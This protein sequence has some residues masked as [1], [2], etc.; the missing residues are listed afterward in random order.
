MMSAQDIKGKK[1]GKVVFG[2]YEASE[3]DNYIDEIA[4]EITLLQKEIL[5]L[6]EQIEEVCE[7]NEEYKSVE[8]SMRKALIS[9]QSIASDMIDKANEERDRILREASEIA[10][11]QIDTYRKQIAQEQQTLSQSQEKTAKF[12][13]AITAFYEKQIKEV[14]EFS[15]EVPAISD[16][17]MHQAKIEDFT[18]DLPKTTLAEVMAPN[19][20]EKNGHTNDILEKIRRETINPQTLSNSQ[21]IEKSEKEDKDFE[22]FIDLDKENSESVVGMIDDLEVKK[23]T[24]KSKFDISELEFGKN[25]TDSNKF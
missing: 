3:V 25:H 18:L 21:K 2:G 16:K 11:E 22:K 5:S 15:R 9:A 19:Q 17:T 20:D 13:S 7:K 6:K 8:Q 23:V 4:D 24:R 1:F 14:I 10:H 12:V